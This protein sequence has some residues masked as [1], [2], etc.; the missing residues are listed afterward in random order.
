MLRLNTIL[1][2][3][4]QSQ[5]SVTPQ[6]PVL[7]RKGSLL[8]LP[9]YTS[10]LSAGTAPTSA[11]LSACMH[12]RML[13]DNDAFLSD[14]WLIREAVVSQIQ[15]LPSGNQDKLDVLGRKNNTMC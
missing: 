2:Q 13:Y 1:T 12:T 6:Q 7:T 8:V 15:L 4:S 5:S 10:M 9:N 14:H 3:T 11:A